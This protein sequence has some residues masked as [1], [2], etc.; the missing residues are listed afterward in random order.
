MPVEKIYDLSFEVMPDGGVELEQG[1]AEVNRISLHACHV[2][3]FLE[4]AGHLLPPLPADEL[5]KRLAERV[6]ALYLAMA[7]DHRHLP[8]NLEDE[9]QS[10]DGFIDGLPDSVFPRHLWEQREERQRAQESKRQA[11]ATSSQVQLEAA[12]QVSPSTETCDGD[13]QARLL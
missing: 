4:R 11:R 12:T 7:D 13:G 6:C 5:S 10:L 3:T 1:F 9:F 2:R 8:R